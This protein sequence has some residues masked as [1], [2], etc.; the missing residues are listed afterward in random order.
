MDF[1]FHVREADRPRHIQNPQDD[2]SRFATRTFTFLRVCRYWNEVSVGF[3]RL[4]SY[5]VAGADK[6]WSLFNSRS[7]GT[8]I[9]LTWRPYLPNS[10]RDI[11]MDPAIPN[12]IHRLDFIGSSDQLA[13]LLGAFDQCPPS[14]LSS[15]RLQISPPDSREPREQLSRFLS[16][17]FPKLTRLDLLNFLPS[18]S[19]PILATPDL[20]SLKFSLSYII[21][22]PYTL[23]QFSQILQRHPN[24]QELDLDCGAI[25]LP[26]PP[27]ALAPF[28]LP[29]LSDLRLHG[30]EG[31]I[32]RFID[33]IGMSSPLHDVTIRFDRNFNLSIRAL[34]STMQTILA[35]YYGSQGLNYPRTVNR[36]AISYNPQERCITFDAQSHHSAMSNVRSNLRF[37]FDGISASEGINTVKAGIPLFP[38]DDLREFAADGFASYGDW[39]RRVFQ[40]MKNRSRLR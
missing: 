28:V 6:A 5:W 14:N 36:L 4:W 9:L 8:P 29:R 10:A 24:L 35:I 37:Q 33:F 32:L 26:G 3:P 30:E 27:S 34:A 11:L 1:H 31:A 15:I 16:F 18:L 39:Y 17:S 23:S 2:D 22:E 38:L 21:G 7:K 13:H 25:P 40:R 20:T 12:R 19:S